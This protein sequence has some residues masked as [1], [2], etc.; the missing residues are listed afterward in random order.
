MDRFDTNN[1]KIF[2]GCNYYLMYKIN[3]EWKCLIKTPFV[4][5]YDRNYSINFRFT[6]CFD[7][8]I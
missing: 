5:N 6:G 4:L 8:L 1:P 2:D 7:V 3:D